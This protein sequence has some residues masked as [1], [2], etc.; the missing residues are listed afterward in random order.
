MEHRCGERVTLRAPVR[1]RR[2]GW[3]SSGVLTDASLSGGFVRTRLQAPVLSL[4]E[5]ELF[6][7]RVSAYVVR[8]QSRGLALEWFEFAPAGIARLLTPLTRFGGR[9]CASTRPL[10]PASVFGSA[11]FRP[12][13]SSIGFGS[14]GPA[15]GRVRIRVGAELDGDGSRKEVERPSEDVGEIPLVRFGH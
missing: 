8:S 11:T 6:G 9:L 13:P 3:D 4:I 2:A 10:R 1:L 7:T 12:A 5:L 14:I 15:L